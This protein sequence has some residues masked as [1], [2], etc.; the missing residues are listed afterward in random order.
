MSAS[1]ARVVEFDELGRTFP[2]PAPVT[3]LA[4]CNLGI[5]GGEFVAIVGPSGSG[6][7]TLLNILGLLDRPSSGCYKLVGVDTTTLSETARASLRVRQIGFV[8]QAFHLLAER[9]VVDNVALPLV[10]LGVAVAERRRRAISVLEQVGLGHRLSMTPLTL[11]GGEKQRV[12]IARAL[13]AEPA[14]VLCDEP[15]GNLDSAASAAVLDVIEDLHDRGGTVVLVTH[16]AQASA[17]AQRIVELRDGRLS[18]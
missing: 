12:A 7:S 5:D 6:K 2:G 13:V 10:Y 18:C 15:T 1:G 14:M 8:F 4:D 11:S 16:D 17:R 9:S 3:A